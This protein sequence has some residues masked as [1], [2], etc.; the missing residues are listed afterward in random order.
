MGHRTFSAN[1][2]SGSDVLG[3]SPLILSFVGIVG[4]SNPLG[5]D[6]DVFNAGSPPGGS[7]PFTVVTDQTWLGAPASGNTDEM[8]AISVNTTGL[9][10]GIYIGHVTIQ[11]SLSPPT[12]ESV[13]VTLTMLAPPTVM[14][15][16]TPSSISA[17]GAVTLNWTTANATSASINE[18]IG[19]V[20]L[21]GN[22]IVFPSVTTVYTI[23]A[24]GP[25]GTANASVT[26]D[27]VASD[28][29][30]SIQKL[31]LTLKQN[32]IPVRGRNK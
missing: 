27:A 14:I 22:L 28:A 19:A 24:T 3:V 10:A 4:G 15:T 23:T 25:G 26:V 11:D 32:A 18:G 7:F 2:S 13:L 5:Q 31:V 6:I 9:V 29:F 8:I 17:G 1:W 30:M 21:N 12:M 16:A 20:A